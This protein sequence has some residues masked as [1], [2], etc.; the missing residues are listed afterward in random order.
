MTIQN[1]RLLNK[2]K[3]KLLPGTTIVRQRL[4]QSWQKQKEHSGRSPLIS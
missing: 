2:T 3:M 4:T 1:A